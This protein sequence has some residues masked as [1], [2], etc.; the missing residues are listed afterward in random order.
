MT[1]L[2]RRTLSCLAL[3]GALFCSTSLS[4]KCH[5]DVK[6]S[7]Y[8]RVAAPSLQ[9][10]VGIGNTAVG[11]AAVGNTEDEV[12][13][14]EAA[15]GRLRHEV[16][17]LR[18]E[19]RELEDLRREVEGQSKGLAKELEGMLESLTFLE[20]ALI[21]AK[22]RRAVVVDELERVDK[23]AAQKHGEAKEGSK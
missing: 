5:D 17:R 6:E 23:K 15:R 12:R 21:E 20:S 16:E 10:P 9:A 19:C 11:H 8:A 18:T 13:Q 7:R 1:M 4:C 2:Q 22:E 14:L 3:A